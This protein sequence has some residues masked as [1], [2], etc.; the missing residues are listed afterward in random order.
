ME[1][2]GKQTINCTVGSCR[3][4]GDGSYCTLRAIQVAP[5]QQVHS[6]SAEEESLCNS[7]RRK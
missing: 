7:Y 3:Y 5:C 1:M 6:G 2:M 4:N